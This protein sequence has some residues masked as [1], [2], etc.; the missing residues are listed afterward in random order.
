M[1]TLLNTQISLDQLDREL[2]ELTREHGHFLD[3]DAFRR[4]LD[5]ASRRH[6]ARWADT[7]ASDADTQLRH[8]LNLAFADLGGAAFALAHHG[9]LNDK[10]LAAHVQRIDELYVQLDALAHTPSVT[11][12]APAAAEHA[13]TA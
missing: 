12:H 6:T 8:E 3:L 13:A 7:Q 9:A 2:R 11:P 1:T 5:S 4:Q 10:R